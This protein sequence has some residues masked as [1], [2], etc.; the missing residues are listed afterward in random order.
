MMASG[1]S[2]T[3]ISIPRCGLQSTYVAALA[4]DD[5]ALDLVTVDVEYRNGILDGR[6]GSYTLDPRWTIIRLASF[7]AGELASSIVSLM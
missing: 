7:V 5:A 2:S 1:V 4:A 6:L 3:M